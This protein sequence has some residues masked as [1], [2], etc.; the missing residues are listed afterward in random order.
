[1]AFGCNRNLS[2]LQRR[3]LQ[4][5]GGT[6]AGTAGYTVLV[7][8]VMLHAHP[9][10]AAIFGL[11]IVAAI[12]VGA[13]IFIVGQYLAQ[14]TDEFVRML[15]MKA[16]LWGF[17]VTMVVDTVYSYLAE[18]AGAGRVSGIQVLN[19]DVFFVSAGIALRLLARGYNSGSEPGS[20]E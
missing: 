9:S 14:E 10:T 17:G 13:L 8:D 11:A 5:F 20:Y 4:K 16:A 7:R 6:I 18:Y 2:P 19:I 1:M 15:V 12:P 3:S